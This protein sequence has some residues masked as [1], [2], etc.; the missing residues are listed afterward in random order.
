MHHQTSC[1][2]TNI[3]RVDDDVGNLLSSLRHKEIGALWNQSTI[4]STWGEL[5]ASVKWAAIKTPGLVAAGTLGMRVPLKSGRQIGS[6]PMINCL[7]GGACSA[8]VVAFRASIIDGV[9]RLISGWE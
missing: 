8:G 1:V 3:N 4:S 6:L 2:T 9:N 5:Y 7:S